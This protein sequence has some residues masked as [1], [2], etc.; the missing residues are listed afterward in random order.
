MGKSDKTK[1]TKDPRRC[2]INDYIRYRFRK[3]YT[4]LN[5]FKASLTSL[6]PDSSIRI[7][8]DQQRVSTLSS[9]SGRSRE[10]SRGNTEDRNVPPQPKDVLASHLAVFAASSTVFK[11]SGTTHDETEIGQMD[12]ASFV[13]NEAG[14]EGNNYII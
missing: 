5:S 14:E 11:N 10:S 4:F 9:S 12:I 6:E 7:I 13:Q 8:P 3:G 2:K 1:N